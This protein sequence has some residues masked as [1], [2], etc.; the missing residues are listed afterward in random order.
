MSSV[1]TTPCHTDAVFADPERVRN[2]VRRRRVRGRRERGGGE[3]ER[4]R[5][6]DRQTDRQTDIQ[7]D[8]QTD[9]QAG[10]QRHTDTQT[11]TKKER[12]RLKDRETESELFVSCLTS[13]QHTSVSQGRIC[14]GNCTCCHTETEVADQT[15]YL[16]MSHYKDIGPTSPNSGPIS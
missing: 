11:D 14:S 3:R 12:Q 6:R 9:R 10:R 1:C 15:F 2:R 8:R 13:Q 5:E 4:E 7:T 16:T